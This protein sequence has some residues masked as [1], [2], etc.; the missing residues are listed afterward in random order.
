VGGERRENGGK[1]KGQE[2][3]GTEKV[4]GKTDAAANMCAKSNVGKCFT[5]TPS[6]RWGKVT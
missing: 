1:R 6:H 2:G 3:K 4:L 5:K